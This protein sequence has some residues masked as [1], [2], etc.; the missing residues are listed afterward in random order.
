[1]PTGRWGGSLRFTRGSRPGAWRFAVT[2]TILDPSA[3][4]RLCF[5]KGQ[6]EP[7]QEA[8]RGVPVVSVV[9]ASRCHLRS[10]HASTAVLGSSDGAATPCSSARR[11]D[12]RAR[13]PWRCL[14]PDRVIEVPPI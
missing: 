4:L 7:F 9:A 5:G 10:M 2:V 6:L 3:L 8:M 1:M 14:D 11:T 12:A 13:R